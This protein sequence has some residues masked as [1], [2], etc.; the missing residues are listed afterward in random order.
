MTHLITWH[1]GSITADLISLII[2]LGKPCTPKAWGVI[3]APVLQ[4]RRRG[5]L[6][7]CKCLDK[8]IHEFLNICIS[9]IWVKNPICNLFNHIGKRMTVV[10]WLTVTTTAVT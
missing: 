4:P 10:F 3:S 2:G 5:V 6:P 8:L 7:L 9:R 1:V